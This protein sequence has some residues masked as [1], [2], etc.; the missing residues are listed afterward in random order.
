[1]REDEN[2]FSRQVA[3]QA[4]R[5]LESRRSGDPGA[6]FGFGMFGMVGWSVAVPTVGGAL[7]GTWLDAHHPNGHSW[8]LALLVAGLVLGCA[9]AWHWVATQHSAIAEPP[10]DDHE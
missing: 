10:P 2:S 7:L 1:M 5:K 4:A 8:T 9:N 3:R 6:W